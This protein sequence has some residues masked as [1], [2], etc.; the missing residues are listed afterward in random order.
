MFKCVTLQ[1]PTRS[2]G[3]VSR[4]RRHHRHQE[5]LCQDLRRRRRSRRR[6]EEVRPPNQT[7]RRSIFS[8]SKL[9][10]QYSFSSERGASSRFPSPYWVARWHRQ[11]PGQDCLV[12]QAPQHLPAQV[13]QGGPPLEQE[14]QE[15]A[16]RR[17]GRRGAVKKELR[18]PKP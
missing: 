6:R 18:F 14:S 9:D 12:V 11:D 4:R 8:K 17:R 13:R 10:L 2:E 7:V 1:H 16:G 15:E 5:E 3:E